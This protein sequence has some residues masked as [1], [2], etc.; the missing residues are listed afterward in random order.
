MLVGVVHAGFTVSN[1][2]RSVDWYCEVLGLELLS[3]QRN[4]NEYTR[5]LVG[6]EEAVLEIAFFRLPGAGAP[7]GQVLE[8]MQ[9]IAPTGSKPSLR[10]NDVGVGHF[11]LAVDDLTAEYER[12]RDLGVRFRNPPV[13][14][15]EGLNKGKAA[16][17]LL[18]PD[19]ITIELIQPA[20][21]ED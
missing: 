11:A 3:R 10:T 7:S 5:L 20:P 4:D 18:D 12:L 6:M 21:A 16:C 15:S 8:L 17:Y 13:T 19:D 9:Y 14:V 1:L 2:D